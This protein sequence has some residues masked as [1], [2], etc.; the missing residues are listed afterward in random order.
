LDLQG[1][2]SQ[3]VETYHLAIS[4]LRASSDVCRLWLIFLRRNLNVVSGRLPWAF[5][6]SETS[7]SKMFGDFF[8]SVNSAIYSLPVK[9]HLPFGGESSEHW[10]DYSSHNEIIAL[11][12]SCLPETAV[13]QV[14]QD[15]LQTMASNVELVWRFVIFVD[16]VM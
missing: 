8:S 3:A 5:H 16:D 12:L 14:Y 10:N 7:Q 13:H 2:H 9:C 6:A 1:A 11:Y 4:C 15:L